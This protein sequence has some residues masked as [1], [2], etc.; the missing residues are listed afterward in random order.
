MAFPVAGAATTPPIFPTGSL[1]PTPP[2]SGTFIPEIWSS[3]LI[4]KFYAST[5]LAAIS[6]TDYEGEIKNKGDKVIIRTKPTITI[7]DYRADGL[8]EVERPSAPTLELVIDKGK[9]F[10]LILDDVMEVQ[11]DLNMMNMWSDD[12]AQQ[13]K[14]VVDREVLLALVGAAAPENR[15]NAAGAISGN[16]ELGI[17]TAPLEVVSRNPTAT[18]V[19]IIDLIVRMGQVLDEQN[20]PETGRWIVI[21]AWV[22]SRIKLSE[23]RDA[24]L[25]GDGTS[26]LRNGRL[27]VIDRF[28]IYVSNLLP[29][30]TAAGL[31]AG[32]TVI[33]AGT[34][35]ALTFASQINKVETLRS[36]HTFGQLLRGLQV[37]GYNVLDGK[38]LV[39]AIIAPPAPTP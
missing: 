27:G 7:K 28:T 14:I 8:L 21:P 10:N 19:E 6:N 15:G 13:F 38:A 12:A 18:Q 22:S 37:Y 32:E 4:E 2:Y 3:K 20:I 16:I 17:T 33:F 25:T 1:T 23:L 11:S 35:H 29:S 34:S 24:S 39:Q 31:A 36:E 5:V 26:I 9:Y 30:G